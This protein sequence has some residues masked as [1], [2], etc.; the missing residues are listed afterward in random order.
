[1]YEN[2]IVEFRDSDMAGE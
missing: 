1:V 2:K